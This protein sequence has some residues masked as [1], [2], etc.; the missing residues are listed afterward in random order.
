MTALER[1]SIVSSIR[2]RGFDI[3]DWERAG[4]EAS[5]QTGKQASE[6]AS[7]EANKHTGKQADT[8]NFDDEKRESVKHS[9]IEALGQ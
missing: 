6:Q 4:K 3:D 1:A 5:K 9:S 7:K 8:Q 2:G